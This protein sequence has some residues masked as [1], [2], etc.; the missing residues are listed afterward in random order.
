[1]KK[2]LYFFLPGY[3]KAQSMQV[4]S[5]K[6]FEGAAVHVPSNRGRCIAMSPYIICSYHQYRFNSNSKIIIALLPIVMAIN[7]LVITVAFMFVVICQ[8]VCHSCFFA[9]IHSATFSTHGQ[10]FA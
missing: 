3:F 1:M 9:W 2:S 8:D 6:L 5:P 10:C 4:Q 7:S